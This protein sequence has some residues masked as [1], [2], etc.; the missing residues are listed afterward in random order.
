MDRPGTP[1]CMHVLPRV[2]ARLAR[3]EELAA[4]LAYT[5]DR[6]TRALF[7]RLNPQLWSAAG[8]NPRAFLR[9]IDEPCLVQ[10]AQDPDFLAAYER[11]LAAYDVYR[12]DT[13]RRGTGTQLGADDLVAYFCAE[14]GFHESLPIYSGGL[15][16][17]AGD[18]CKAAS[19]LRLPFVAVGLLYRQGYFSQTIDAEGNQVATYTDSDFDDLPV[20]P[21]KDA[22]GAELRV[23]IEFPGRTVQLRVWRARVG[24]VALYL[25]DTD[26]PENA[27]RDRL[28]TYRLYG[29]DRTTRI[30]QEIVLGMGGVRALAALG[31][32]PTV[33]HINEGHAAFLV[34]ERLRQAVKAG[35]SFA[36][37][38]EAVAGSTVF[39]THTAV[40]AGHDRFPNDMVATYFDG[41]CREL[42][43]ER[44]ALFALGRNGADDEFDMT[45]LAVRGS[46]WQNGVSRIHRGV[47]A[48]QLAALWPQVPAEENPVTSIT[49]GVH[50][51]T[52]LAPE[53]A[54]VFDR[55]LG[56]TWQHHLHD[57]AFWARVAELPDELFWKTHQT[58]KAQMLYLVRYRVRAQHN[59]HRTS[60]SHIERLLRFADPERPEVL[61]IGFGR[62]FAA[63][64][65]ATL[66]FENL[67]WLREIVADRE[68][69]VLFIF[70]G[71]AH[72]ADG[73]G[74]DLIRH[75]SRVART[76]EFEGRI[77]L[78]EEYDLRLA[79]R[80]VSGVDVWLNNPVYPLEASGTSGMKA[81]MNGVLN[82][83][84]LD[85]WWGEG[86]TGDNGWAIKPASEALDPHRRN[87]EE[88][89]TLYELLQDRV[90]PLYYERDA[91]GLP[92]GWI[93]MA[94]R[95]IATIMPRF[96]AS[97]MVDEYV[98][99]CYLPAAR[100]R[101]RLLED[102]GAAARALADWR[103]RVRAAWPGVSIRR[104]DSPAR[105]IR[106]GDRVRAEVAVRLNG[107]APADVRV[108][109]R[110]ARG[111]KTE[112][113]SYLFQP[114]GSPDA[115]GEQR[116]ALE[117]APELCGRL[118]Y[119]IRAYPHHPLLAHPLEMG[120]MIW[121]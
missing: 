19:D 119:R 36:A 85:G 25:L 86:Y 116:Y 74:Q 105:Q 12:R 43:I 17:L 69:P 93:R 22:G 120:L 84:V 48:Q 33:W 65:R 101:R 45:A 99:N 7:S 118:E 79:R 77:L 60:E 78:V 16:I 27:E 72:P 23:P 30:E 108:E 63:Y 10:A 117:F 34:L 21:V 40:A 46:R 26:L 73:P 106:Y 39:T 47:S 114:D 41:W 102:G 3:L 98:A 50:A 8:H 81:A 110:L 53:W 56:E 88:A 100:L 18:H 103:V 6:A 109:L 44:A 121:A 66:L 82:L 97:R 29:G 32:E 68:R 96:N 5:W 91:R 42:G 37:A 90:V 58:L 71:K 62:R 54:D 89:R 107:L 92:L 59:R 49:N 113:R 94:K 14:F 55:T 76:P 61:T 104:L 70:A 4:D 28:I 80:L 38:L 111:A 87:Q 64:K 67:D 9:R 95:A 24:H 75:I 1:Y 13:A 35:L 31:L 2:P 11:V 57:P 112:W 52:F 83:S 15:G 20:E 51:P 115:A